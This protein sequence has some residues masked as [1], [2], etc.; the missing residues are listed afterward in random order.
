MARQ[1]GPPYS[2]G[3]GWKNWAI[4]AVLAVI[5]V[6]GGYAAYRTFGPSHQERPTSD[7]A[8]N[9]PSALSPYDSDQLPAPEIAPEPE[10][11]PPQTMKRPKVVPAPEPIEAVVGIAPEEEPPTT[12]EIVVAGA[13]RP[14]WAQTPSRR[15]LSTIY[16]ERELQDG[17]EG[18]AQLTCTVLPDG[19][20]DCTRVSETSIGFGRAAL[21]LSRMYKHAPERW[22]GAAAAGSTLNLR[23]VFRM[24]EDSRRRRR[25]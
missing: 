20:L 9:D 19:A 3:G 23:V 14:I 17:R 22:D 11:P 24:S 25:G 4:G 6:G 13:R 16:P 15:R 18:E 5:L 2:D 7:L 21:R 10:A 8:A 1:P 12:D